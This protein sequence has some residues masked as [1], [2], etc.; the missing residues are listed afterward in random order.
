MRPITARMM[1]AKITFLPPLERD[2]LY[3]CLL[4]H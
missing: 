3:I 1:S 4:Y 2:S